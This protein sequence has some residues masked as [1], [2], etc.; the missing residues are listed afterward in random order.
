MNQGHKS[1]AQ[2]FQ[3]CADSSMKHEREMAT[4]NELFPRKDGKLWENWIGLSEDKRTQVYEACYNKNT[5][6]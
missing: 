1:W 2:A 5:Q 4:T 6:I 3:E